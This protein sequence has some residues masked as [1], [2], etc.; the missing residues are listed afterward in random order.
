MPYRSLR[1]ATGREDVS[2]GRGGRPMAY[3]WRI[4]ANSASA[5]VTGYGN[6][7]SREPEHRNPVVVV[8]FGKR[9]PQCPRKIPPETSRRRFDRGT[10]R[11]II[12]L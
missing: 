4:T 2:N 3:G 11:T 9:K 8:G 6:E 7:R 12:V 10:F 1:E 5:S